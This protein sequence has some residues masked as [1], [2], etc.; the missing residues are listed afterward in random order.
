MRRILGL[1]IFEVVFADILAL[2][3]LFPLAA[4][5]RSLF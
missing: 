2:I 3:V 1:P 5:I 4:W